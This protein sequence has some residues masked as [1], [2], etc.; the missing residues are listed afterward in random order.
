[1]RSPLLLVALVAALPGCTFSVNPILTSSDL[2]SDVDLTGTWEQQVPIGAEPRSKP[3]VVTLDG[4]DNNSSYDAVY[5]NHA[6]AFEVHIG[7]LDGRRY[8]QCIRVDLS[9]K[10]ESPILARVPVYGFAKFE[11]EGDKLRV[12]SVNDQEVRKLLKGN[13][14]GFRDYE[15]SDMLEWCII[16]ERTSRIQKLICEHGDE[17]FQ[18]A[19]DSVPSRASA[20]GCE[21]TIKPLT[22]RGTSR[23]SRA[24]F[25]N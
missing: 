7:K 4:Y 12:F 22:S 5:T 10:N 24:L 11:V 8:L 9:L 19:T 14:I 17:L 25:N 16:T 3:T 6:Q 23:C 18:G 21:R 15:P 2:T 20:E 1:M 13:D